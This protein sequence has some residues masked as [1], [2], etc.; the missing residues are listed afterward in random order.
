[1]EIINVLFF[2][3]YLLI[4]KSHM[5]PLRKCLIPHLCAFV[6]AFSALHILFFFQLFT[7]S[8][9]I[10]HN[11]PQPTHLSLPHSHPS[12][13]Q[14]PINWEKQN[15]MEAVGC[16]SV[17]HSSPFCPHFAGKCLCSKSL[18]WNK[19]FLASSTLSKLELHWVSSCMSF[20][21]CVMV[22]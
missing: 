21:P 17:S 19:A 15:L 6:K 20:L 1:M 14:S 11:A 22:I 5:Y 10:S 16:H 8:L 4:N 2:S 9:W 18:V 13:L 7:G 3:R 12:P